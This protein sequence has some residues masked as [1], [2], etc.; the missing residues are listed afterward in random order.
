[1]RWLLSWS[2][3]GLPA[4]WIMRRLL[5]RATFAVL[6]AA[7]CSLG[8]CSARAPEANGANAAAGATGSTVGC[9]A[10]DG[11]VYAA[12]LQKSGSAGHFDFT[13][14]S[15]TPGPPSL[16]DNQFVVQVSD[17]EG[18]AV[19]GE[20]RVV[21]DMPEHGHRSPKQPDIHFDADSQAFVLE[22]IYFFM[23]GLWRITFSF[24][25]AS[26]GASLTDSAVFQFCVD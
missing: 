25:G 1:V 19:T 17:G 13:L 4:S 20:L 22:P 5:R 9:T 14:V 10:S 24:E 15:S 8:A 3:P 7:S 11:D 2:A 26:A 18:K 21:L 16:E 12:G 23:V 6:L